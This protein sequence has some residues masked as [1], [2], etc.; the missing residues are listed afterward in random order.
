VADDELS[1]PLAIK[2]A[3]KG[4]KVIGYQNGDPVPSGLNHGNAYAPLV[5][6]PAAGGN[7]YLPLPRTGT[8]ITGLVHNDNN[9][10]MG[11]ET[12]PII[13]P[14]PQD[15]D[16]GDNGDGDGNDDDDEDTANQRAKAALSKQITQQ[17]IRTEP[18]TPQH[19]AQSQGQFRSEHGAPQQHRPQSYNGQP[20]HPQSRAVATH[21][22]MHHLLPSGPQPGFVRQPNFPI[23]QMTAQEVH[24]TAAA[25]NQGQA[26]AVRNQG[27]ARAHGGGGG[28]GT[29]TGTD[30]GAGMAAQHQ[31]QQQQ[32]QQQRSN[33]SDDMTSASTRLPTP[34]DGDAHDDDDNGEALNAF[35][36]AMFGAGGNGADDFFDWHS[37]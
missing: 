16:E 3:I 31:P 34:H 14:E 25:R 29:G 11:V 5:T 33:V 26:T 15:E 35:N 27:H 13:K 19:H 18:V 10:E 23:R 1:S 4:E 12:K 32:Q 20:F 17:Q 24:A 36:A 7:G 37:Y 8:A 22:P 9:A 2:S 21:Q 28:N 6:A 30:A